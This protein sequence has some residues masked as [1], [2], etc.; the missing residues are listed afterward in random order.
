VRVISPPGD[1]R[2][3]MLHI[4]GGGFAFGTPAMAD[5]DNSALARSAGIATVSV[6]YRLAPQNPHPAALDDCEAALLWLLG[7]AQERFGTQRILIG[8]ESVGATLAVL[9]LLRLRDRH[10]SEKL[11]CGANLVVGCYDF[12][13]TPSQRQS[14]S[15]L[16]LSPERL[17]A[18]VAAA[19]P[20]REPE[21]LRDPQLSP[22]YADL[23]GLP[24]ALFSI[25]TEDAVLDD[26][27]F[28]AMRW[29]AAGN[30]AELAVYP[31]GPHLFLQLPTQMAVEG[32][33]RIAAFLGRCITS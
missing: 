19:F 5:R 3:V 24:P 22:L 27:L 15:T 28:M 16:F 29:R 9:A 2:A 30:L 26:S 11:I 18:T 4:H 23:R 6:Q 20:G 10:Q 13:M 12:S 1:V 25:G 7:A 17:R 14:A 31:E 8:G 33:G 32:Q 21:A